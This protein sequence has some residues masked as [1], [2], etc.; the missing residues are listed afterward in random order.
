MKKSIHNVE[1][2]KQTNKTSTVSYVVKETE[3][4]VQKVA[5]INILGESSTDMEKGRDARTLPAEIFEI[6]RNF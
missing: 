3:K 6:C 2:G 5:K 4:F 1:S